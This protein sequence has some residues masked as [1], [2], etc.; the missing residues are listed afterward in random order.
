MR[1]KYSVQR[2]ASILPPKNNPPGPQYRCTRSNRAAPSV[3]PK[4][5]HRANIT[6]KPFENCWFST[7]HS[8]NVIV[9]ER[10]TLIFFLSYILFVISYGVLGS[11]PSR[12][13]PP[14]SG[15]FPF[16]RSRF[17]RVFVRFWP[18]LFPPRRYIRRTTFLRNIV[19]D[20]LYR[21]CEKS[22]YRNNTCII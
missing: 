21:C 7:Y 10:R 22:E 1:W 8:K 2:I 15:N 4:Q 16:Y 12:L 20:G 17:F 6:W 9:V 5:K 13:I 19:R 18:T 3:R 11:Y 14:F